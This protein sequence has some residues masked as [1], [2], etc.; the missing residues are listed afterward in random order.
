M[1]LV[2]LVAGA[3]MLLATLD[4]A[5]ALCCPPGCV[6]NGNGGCVTTGPAPQ[7][8][9]HVACSGAGND[10]GS[11]GG[12]S[13]IAP[14][15][16]GPAPPPPACFETGASPEMEA[17]AAAKCMT[18][19]SANAQLLGCLLE[20]DAGKRED[21]RTGL[22]CAQREAAMAKQCASRCETF[23]HLTVDRTCTYDG[24]TDRM[25]QIAFGDLAGPAVGVARVDGCGPPLRSKLDLGHPGRTRHT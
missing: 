3:S 23:A 4:A 22:T 2:L 9:G 17:S 18:A 24:F 25:W 5:A 7:V 16:Q 10:V 14:P 21:K 19:V 6:Q 11:G 8:C 1:N 15:A 13:G 12:G 20:D